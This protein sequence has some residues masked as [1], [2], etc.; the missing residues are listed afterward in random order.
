MQLRP[1]RYKEESFYKLVNPLFIVHCA[2]DDSTDVF[3]VDL[4]VA[5]WQQDNH[6]LNKTNSN[7]ITCLTPLTIIGDCGGKWKLLLCNGVAR[8]V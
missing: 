8:L 3:L 2:E 7:L 5:A 1:L 6:R 4:L